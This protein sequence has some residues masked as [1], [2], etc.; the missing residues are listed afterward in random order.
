MTAG[1]TGYS[2]TACVSLYARA[3][4]S[5]TTISAAVIPAVSAISTA[6]IAAGIA[7]ADPAASR[8][9]GTLSSTSAAAATATNWQ[10]MLQPG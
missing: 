6:N 8:A 9:P 1:R 4:V 10:M 3:T 5:S 2:V 7:T